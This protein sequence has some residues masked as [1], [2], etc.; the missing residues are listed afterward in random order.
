MV[1]PSSAS[2]LYTALHAYLAACGVDGVKVDAQS[3]ASMMGQVRRC[4]T[5][6]CVLRQNSTGMANPVLTLEYGGT[7]T[8][9]AWPTRY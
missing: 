7:R 6:T 1:P 3:L 8:V 2:S 4:L 5:R 9:R